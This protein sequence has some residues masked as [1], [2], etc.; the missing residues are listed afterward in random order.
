[1][2]KDELVDRLMQLRGNPEIWLEVATSHLEDNYQIFDTVDCIRIDEDG[3]LVIR[4][5][6]AVLLEMDLDEDEEEDED[7]R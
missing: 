5:E 1:M 4:G 2:K 6:E 3:D 7:D